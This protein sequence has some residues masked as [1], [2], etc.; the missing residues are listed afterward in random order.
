MNRACR[1][2]A[3]VALLCPLMA[4]QSL[5]PRRTIEVESPWQ[6]FDDA[7]AAF[8]QVKIGTTTRGELEALG[9]DPFKNQNMAILTYMD[10]FE[11]FVPND[12]VKIEQLDPG[13]QKCIS[14]RDRC[15][16]VETV[17]FREWDREY[18]NFFLNFFQFR[19]K[20]EIT[21]WLFDA[22]IVLVDDTV[23][24][25]LWQGSPSIVKRQQQTK[26]L[27]FLQDFEIDFKVKFP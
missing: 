14:V 6:T 22:T 11:E 10:V 2:L 26:P 25:K 5:L 21:G 17:I 23:V 27:G 7:V 13:V 20:A 4:C 3:V 24:Y 19:T 1:P 18:G 9:F 8:D 12:A 16:A 15:R